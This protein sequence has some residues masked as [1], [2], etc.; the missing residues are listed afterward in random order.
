MMTDSNSTLAA[1]LAESDL[2]EFSDWQ[3]AQVLNAP[4]PSLPEI[5]TIERTMVNSITVMECLGFEEGADFLAALRDSGIEQLVQA[6]IAMQP[7]SDGLNI[8]KPSLRVAISALT[9]PPDTL[10]TPAQGAALLAL[11]EKKRHLSWAEHHNIKVTDHT[12]GE[13]RLAA[14]G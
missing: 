1:R 5:T 3:A 4:D 6:Y 12:V 10:L 2:Q 11:A 8:A 9:Q 14:G 7:P 13:A